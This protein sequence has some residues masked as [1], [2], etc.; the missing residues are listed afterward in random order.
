MKEYNYCQKIVC[1]GD[2]S[3]YSFIKGLLPTKLR[4]QLTNEEFHNNDII[5]KYNQNDFIER[6][7]DKNIISISLNIVPIVKVIH[8]PLDYFKINSGEECIDKLLMFNSF[9]YGKLDLIGDLEALLKENV[10]GDVAA[11]LY[12]ENRRFGAT[13]LSSEEESINRAKDN[14]SKKF[15][16]TIV[17]NSKRFDEEI[18]EISP[19]F[20]RTFKDSHKNRYFKAKNKFENR[21]EKQ[22][23]FNIK[24]YFNMFTILDPDE[25]EKFK[26][27]FSFENV[28]NSSDI[29][30]KFKLDFKEQYIDGDF[31]MLNI[32]EKLYKKFIEDICIWDLKDDLA[33]LKKVVLD[34]YEQHFGKEK[35]LETPN[36]ELEYIK[37]MNIEEE[38]EENQLSRIFNKKTISFVD[39]TLKILLHTYINNHFNNIKQ[40]QENKNE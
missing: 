36:T 32:V 19:D 21:Y 12:C 11:I 5:L 30:G 17:Y 6:Y 24:N 16:K 34:A 18:F 31:G 23:E 9:P 20:I 28:R 14:Y 8:I 29:W 2:E 39:N 1:V 13:D 38:E 37:L 22:Y 7:P 35:K 26:K 27:L 15:I 3:R 40:G 33:N 10:I 25:Y 4:A